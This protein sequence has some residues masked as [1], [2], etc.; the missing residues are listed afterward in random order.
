MGYAVVERDVL[1]TK[2]STKNNLYTH[3]FITMLTTNNKYP[4][5]DLSE[6]VPD[7]DIP[8]KPYQS[9][10]PVKAGNY[11]P[12]LK[13]LNDYSRWQ[14]FFNGAQT[15]GPISLRQLLNKP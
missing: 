9:L 4:F 5:F 12:D 2:T 1:I 8:F 15:H 6:I 7:N 14:S 10:K 3:Y 13:F 11:I